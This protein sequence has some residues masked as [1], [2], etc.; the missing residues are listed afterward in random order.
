MKVGDAKKQERK[1]LTWQDPWT[2]IAGHPIP[3]RRIPTGIPTLDTALGGGIPIDSVCLI[4]GPPGSGKTSFAVQIATDAALTGDFI[5]YFALKDEGVRGGSVRMAQNIGLDRKKV[6]A[7]DVATLGEY[8]IRYGPGKLRVSDPDEA[9]FLL[10][11]VVEQMR[12]ETPQGKIPI[13]VAD[14]VQKLPTFMDDQF[15][16]MRFKI[17]YVMELFRRSAKNFFTPIFAISHVV[18]ASYRNKKSEENI[19]GL[20]AGAEGSDIERAADVVIFFEGRTVEGVT[21]TVEKN[22]IGNGSLPTIK[23]QY[24]LATARFME[25]DTEATAEEEGTSFSA[26]EKRRQAEVEDVMDRME[27]RVKKHPGKFNK[28]ELWAGTG[29]RKQ[30]VFRLIDLMCEKDVGR[31]SCDEDSGTYFSGPNPGPKS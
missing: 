4:L 17:A 31:L 7:G 5:A 24:D 3:E 27:K 12:D 10:E 15:E 23:L 8:A 21:L 1:R 6:E 26:T 25:I 13:L 29:M 11:T 22:R 18:R 20:G 14:S 28:T 30:T 9:D 19:K 2:W 16:A